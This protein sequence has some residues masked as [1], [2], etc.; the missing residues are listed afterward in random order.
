MMQQ[1]TPPQSREPSSI[2]LKVMFTSSATE[3]AEEE[4][5]EERANE[6][7]GDRKCHEARV[8]QELTPPQT[9]VHSPSRYAPAKA[10]LNLVRSS[11]DHFSLRKSGHDVV[12]DGKSLQIV[13]VVAVA[14]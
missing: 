2:N 4:V 11:F 9:R 10:H 6:P 5:R 13:D 7:R 12:L 8:Q 1:P 3:V 14:K